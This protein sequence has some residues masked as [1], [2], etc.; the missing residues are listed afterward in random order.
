MSLEQVTA[1]VQ[2]RPDDLTARYR[3]AS[4]LARA[5]RHREAIPLFLSVIQQDPT[6]AEVLNDLGVSYLLLQRYHESLLALRGATQAEPG[7]AAAWGNL[8]R[9]HMATKMPFTAVRE[10]RQAAKLDPRSLPIR[11]DLGEAYQRTLNLNSAVLI[12]QEVLK[13]RPRDV[14]ALL[15]LGKTYYSL[16]RYAEAEPPL[17]KAIEVDPNSAG[18]LL[19]LARL[20]LERGGPGSDPASLRELLQRSAE[21]DP[22]EP[23]VWYDLGRLSMREGRPARAVELFRRALRI[24]EEHPGATYQLARALS[25]AG[26]PVAADRVTRIMRDISLRSREESRLEERV[27][28]RPT[29][30][31]SQVR[32]AELYLQGGKTDLAALVCRQL[33]QGAA[34]DPRL[35][36]LLAELER[37]NRE[38][39]AHRSDTP[40]GGAGPSTP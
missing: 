22:Q 10:L 29:D 21:A 35:P 13:Q 34:S 11:L 24:S 37:Q 1:R 19:A 26:Q 38:V 8:G 36:K 32:L 12:Y 4:L 16:A 9:L 23:E 30:W 17:R 5:D 40:A 27:R 2:Q 39:A 25:A 7:F 15:G 14:T 28:E 33:Q 18:A 3:L 20:R 31:D 6:R